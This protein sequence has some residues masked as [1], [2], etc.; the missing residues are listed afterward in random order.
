MY[1]KIHQHQKHNKLWGNKVNSSR[2][3]NYHFELRTILTVTMAEMSSVDR[4]LIKTIAED[5]S[6]HVK[7]FNKAEIECLIQQFNVLLRELNS[8]GETATGL[9]RGKF[10]SVLHKNFGMTEDLIMDGIFRIFD[11]D[12][13]SFVSVKEWIAGLSVFFRGTLDEKIKYCFQV[14][15]LNSDGFISREE[16]FHMLKNSLVEQPTEEDPDE[17]IKDLVEITLKMMD[18]DRDGT[19]SFAD[20]EKTVREQ[21]LLLEAF[22]TCLP[23]MTC[24][25]KFEEQIFQPKRRKMKNSS[26]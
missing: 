7:H 9:D 3:P 16:I 15:D 19:V 4:K 11:K 26:V 14:Y 21:S 2:H 10:R 13:D 5:I 17:G 20:Y 18:H 8:P 12:G 23:D 6:K 22:G 25:K 1:L 24:T